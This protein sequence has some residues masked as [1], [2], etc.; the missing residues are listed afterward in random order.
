MRLLASLT[1]VLAV[2]RAAEPEGAPAQVLLRAAG[3]SIELP[4]RAELA[5]V[6]EGSAFPPLSFRR[7]GDDAVGTAADA[8]REVEV[9]LR[10]AGASVSLEVRVRYLADAAAEREAIRLSL[11]GPVRAIAH[12]LSWRA[13][14]KSL[15]VDRG[16]PI[17]L[18]ARQLAVVGGPGFVAARVTPRS[19]GADLELVLDDEA[20]HPFAVYER[21]LPRLPE[22]EDGQVHF[23]ELEHKRPESRMPRRRGEEVRGRATLYLLDGAP[24]LPLVVERWPAGT[25]AAVVFTDH[26]DRT[27][28]EALRAVLY[29]DSRP[30][31]RPAGPGGFL[32]RG[33]R[34]TK[35]FFVHARRGAL[36]DPE[37]AS[38]AR[39]LAMA[40][41]EV[42]S[43]SPSP[44]PDDREAV[45]GALP[46]LRRFGVVTW[47]DHEPYTNCEAIS[48]EGWRADGPYAVRDLLA[49]GGFRW[50]WEAGDV[51]GFAREP[52]VGN[53]FAPGLA[54]AFYPMP[55]DGKLW[56]FG[57]TMFQ[58]TPEA[59]AR[60]LS[61]AAL[62]RLEGERGLFVGHTYLAAAP[63]TT[64]RPDLLARLV[65]REVD[66]GLELHPAFDEAL[67]RLA[68]R[69][70]SG[71]L[72]SL[73]WDEAGTRLRA[74]GDVEVSY[75]PDGSAEVVNRGAVPISGLTVSVPLPNL[76]L[77]L[78]G[79]E[80]DGAENLPASSRAWFDL[81]PGGAA[82]VRAS[83][84]GRPMRLVAAAPAAVEIVG[85]KP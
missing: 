65:V 23:A 18:A 4:V 30:F 77:E 12:D 27:D 64:T 10:P 66:G 42:A 54:P 84:G 31:C 7:D 80:V 70:R 62:D 37:T 32:G 25:R 21:C 74:I 76:V 57:S 58:G 36:E 46:L 56:V 72:A 35:S 71:T 28:P 29:G 78:E 53:L 85:G 47:I 6:E 26:A 61:D 49:G 50:V 48:A 2:A 33:L 41:S 43:H 82:V 24:A 38:L 5:P 14:A 11:P 75:R 52:V 8:L 60:A 79:V 73:T 68:A 59:L 55:L 19:G 34:I 17:A 9:R 67:E 40:G 45:R 16:T 39:E 22:D 1:L 63:R 69:V 15:R 51:G 83:E 20:S 3:R 44:L 13:V 81:P